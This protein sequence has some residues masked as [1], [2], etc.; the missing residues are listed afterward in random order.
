MCILVAEKGAYN[1][2]AFFPLL[3]Y[4]KIYIKYQDFPGSPVVKTW[5][6]NAEGVCSLPG[7]GAKTPHASK[8]KKP[9]VK[10]KAIVVT[11]LIDFRNGPHKKKILKKTHIKSLS[12][13]IQDLALSAVSLNPRT[14]HGA[15]ARPLALARGPACSCLPLGLCSRSSFYLSPL[16]QGI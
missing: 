4:V 14:P 3:N 10:T 6:S 5:P 11:N 16:Y 7:W 13:L 15:C 2:I 8:P 1:S 9:R 12:H